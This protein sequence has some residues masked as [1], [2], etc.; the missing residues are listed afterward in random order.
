LTGLDG[1]ACIGGEI[2]R[3]LKINFRVHEHPGIENEREK[4]KERQQHRSDEDRNLTFFTLL[5]SEN[6]RSGTFEFH[7]V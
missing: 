4:K 5:F 1:G 7:V 6:A 2:S 3:V